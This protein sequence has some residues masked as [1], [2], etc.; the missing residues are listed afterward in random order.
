MTL[1]IKTFN[2][3]GVAYLTHGRDE[4]VCIISGGKRDKITI[5]EKLLLLLL[6]HLGVTKLHNFGNEY[7]N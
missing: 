2:V 3:M 7:T 5:D 4:N 6:C 1:G